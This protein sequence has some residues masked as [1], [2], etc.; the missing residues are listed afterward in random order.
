MPVFRKAPPKES[1][2]HAEKLPFELEAD[3][4]TFVAEPRVRDD[5]FESATADDEEDF[6]QATEETREDSIE[7]SPWVSAGQTRKWLAVRNPQTWLNNAVREVMNRPGD[8]SL[9][10]AT[11]V[12]AITLGWALWPRGASPALASAQA[13]PT[14]VKRPPRPQAPKLTFMERALV[15]VGLAVPPPAPQYTG[16]PNVKVWEDPQNGLYY[17]PDADLYGTTPKGRYATQGEAQLDSF[18]PASHRFCD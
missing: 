11:V 16:D 8:V 7:V 18:D 9:M 12:L 1:I 17:C 2:P 6:L 4:D 5:A 3:D 10:A 15:A 14:T 13:L